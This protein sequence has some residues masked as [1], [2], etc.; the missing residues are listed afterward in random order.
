MEPAA[1]LKIETDALCD[2]IEQ[3]ER[4]LVAKAIAFNDAEQLWDSTL[5]PQSRALAERLLA[6]SFQHGNPYFEMRYDDGGPIV[7]ATSPIIRNIDEAFE[8]AAAVQLLRAV[9]R[10]LRDLTNYLRA[11]AS[12]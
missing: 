2:E 11:A 12:A 8:E 5:Q 7:G 6:S 3:L 9:A 1:A 10:Q 4:K